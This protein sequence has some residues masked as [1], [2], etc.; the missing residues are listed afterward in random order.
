MRNNH[1][2]NGK[3]NKKPKKL[4]KIKK[5]K[6]RS[7][8]NRC[9]ENQPRCMACGS[10]NEL[11]VHHIIFKSQGGDDRLSNLIILCFEC[12]RKCHDGFY[13]NKK[14]K[15]GLWFIIALLTILNMEIYKET[16]EILKNKEEKL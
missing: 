11:A 15:S 2:Y 9:K 10:T 5:V 7:N 1:I 3:E 4:I 8:I 16:L 14:Y 13:R 6:S 12:H